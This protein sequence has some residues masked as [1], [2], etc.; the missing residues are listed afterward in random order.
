VSR[1]AERFRREEEKKRRESEKKIEKVEGGLFESLKRVLLFEEEKF[2]KSST[3]K[4]FEFVTAGSLQR[5][6]F[7]RQEA[8]L[9]KRIENFNKRFGERTLSESEFNFA[10]KSVRIL[11]DILIICDFIEQFVIFFEEIDGKQRYYTPRLA[12][13]YW[14]REILEAIQTMLERHLNSFTD[15]DESRNAFYYIIRWFNG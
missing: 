9:N 13:Y 14:S 12:I 6:E 4:I 8:D 2:A 7:D 1:E 10:K 5:R 15:D 3:G 11:H